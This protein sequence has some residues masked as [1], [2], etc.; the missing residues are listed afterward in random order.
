[1]ERACVVGGG[2]V[3]M[4]V[5]VAVHVPEFAAQILLR[6]RRELRGKPVA[7]LEGERPFERV[8]G[9]NAKARQMGVRSG[10]TR[11]EVE[12]FSIALLRRSTSEE[13]SARAVLQSLLGGFTPKIEEHGE[14]NTWAY[15]LDM[16]GTERLSGSVQSAAE[17]IRSSLSE[18][19]FEVRIAISDNFHAALYLARSAR[20]EIIHVPHGAPRRF[21]S[22]LPLQLLNMHEEDAEVLSGWGV[23]TLGELA[24][25]PEI[26][27]IARLGQEG[28]RLRQLACGEY[29]HLFRPLEALA[30]LEEY[31]EFDAPVEVLESLLF[32]INSMI[33]QLIKRAGS[34]ALALASITAVCEQ[35]GAPP[36]TR[37]V[38]SALPTEDRKALLKLLQLDLEA[39]PP[40]AG[41]TAI[42]LT[43]DPGPL[44]KVQ[45]GLFSPQLPEPM[46]LDVTLA[47]V[48]AIVGEKRVGKP[49]LK[50]THHSD[51]FTIAR[52]TADAIST[53]R[54]QSRTS[55]GLRRFRPPATVKVEIANGRLKAFWHERV[56]YDVKRLY[57]PWRTSG[58]WWSGDV[59]SGDGWDFAAEAK[60]GSLLV[61]VARH[62]RLRHVWELEA[63][64]D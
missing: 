16:S 26:D 10:M 19:D 18:L 40:L 44:S 29:K 13:V 32:A 15:V 1:M 42:R 63:L 46:R 47:R 21:L 11:T 58:D 50:D 27:L 57:G 55:F 35:E 34:R 60:D 25:L 4:P 17:T 59:W 9:M 6:L 30:T 43:A 22:P 49:V 2:A 28:R 56:R 39:H 20:R 38:R 41:V 23:R 33:E 37:S 5:Y 24:E 52:F 31:V 8:C 36:H 53:I 45:I 14:D 64:Y 7:V 12:P 54:S 51:A 48:A 3:D 61:G 62:D